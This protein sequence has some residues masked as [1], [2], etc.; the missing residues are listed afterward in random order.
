M[1][2]RVVEEENKT[3]KKKRYQ[4]PCQVDFN[5]SAFKLDVVAKYLKLSMRS[6]RLGGLGGASALVTRVDAVRVDPVSNDLTL[7]T[8]LRRGDDRWLVP[9][10]DDL[11]LPTRTRRGICGI[12]GTVS[13]SVVARVDA[14]TNER[15]LSTRRGPPGPPASPLAAAALRGERGY[16]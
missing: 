14:V 15:T 6:M 16:S 2:W 13:V 10:D 12:S 7:G 3:S 5:S 8:G 9:D 11:T 1:K 4:I